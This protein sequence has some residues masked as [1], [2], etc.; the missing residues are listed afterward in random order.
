MPPLLYKHFWGLVD[1]DVTNSLLSWLNLG[2]IPYPLNHTFVTLI[3]KTKNPEYVTQY[4]PISLCNVL[5]KIFSKVL[6]NRFKKILRTIITEHQYAF[7]K[8]RL[9]SNNILVAF[10]SLNSMKNMSLRKTGYMAIKLDMSKAY[11]RVEWGYLENVMRK[12]GFNERW[13][14]L[15]MVCVKT[16]TYSIMVYGEPQGLIH[17]TS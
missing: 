5:Y 10:E 13:I 9:I 4:Q 16:V 17:P 3:P 11:D 6:A 7:V 12:M 15:I 1:N 14:G 2:T 8:N